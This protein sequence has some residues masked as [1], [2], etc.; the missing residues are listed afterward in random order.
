[1]KEG[2]QSVVLDHILLMICEI[3]SMLR[4]RQE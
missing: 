4:L 3:F 2:Y 1:L